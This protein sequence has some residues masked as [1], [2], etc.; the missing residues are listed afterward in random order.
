MKKYLT[1]SA[2]LAVFV[3]AFSLSCRRKP[4]AESE[5]PGPKTP[6]KNEAN[7]VEPKQVIKAAAEVA[8]EGVAVTVNGVAIMETDIEGDIKKMT[9]QAP[10]AIVE[11]NK[12]QI[13]RQVLDRRIA[14]QLISEK[15]K[16]AQ[17]T[18]TEEDILA[19]VTEI[20]AQQ[21]MSLEDFKKMLQSRG[22]DYGEW[23]QQI[24]WGV[25]L[26]KLV[27]ADYGDQLN[28][29]DADA[30]NV[31]SANLKQ[32][33]TPEQVKASHIL[34]KPVTDPNVDPNEAK[35]KAL[36]KAQDLLKQAKEKG[37][38]F[39][40]LAKA[41]GGYPSAPRGGDLGFRPRG[42]WDARFEKAAFELK[43]GQISDVV[44]TQLGYHIIKVTDKKEAS[45]KTFEQVRDE[46]KSTLKRRKQGELFQKYLVQIRAEAKI[47]YPPGK[48][49]PPVAPRP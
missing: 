9:A 30:N 21:K 45:R 12:E 7:V 4:E 46:I 26:G 24:Q 20:V 44:E 1:I 32:F 6:A 23:E 35:A 43:V 48:E 8:A 34:I 11:K 31:Y 27:E 14:I 42:V 38:D 39:A 5:E 40:E 13:K 41:T 18:V 10:P 36:A 3:V 16:A 33:E 25:M 29:T 22:M 17:I 15:A 47:V 19:Q 28:V 37:V 2:C 49:P